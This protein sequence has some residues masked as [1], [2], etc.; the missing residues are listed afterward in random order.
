MN[1]KVERTPE[2]RKLLPQLETMY[3]VR[4]RSKERERMPKLSSETEEI[5]WKIMGKDLG[6]A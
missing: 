1:Q 2:L 4:I 5:L 3:E 6:K